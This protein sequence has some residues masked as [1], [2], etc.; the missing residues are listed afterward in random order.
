MDD[1]KLLHK[2]IEVVSDI[3]N[4][5]EKRFGEISVVREGK[6]TFLGMNIEINYNTI[7]FDMVK[8][9]EECI[10]ICGT[11][12]ITLVTSTATKKIFEVREYDEQ[13]IEKKG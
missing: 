12:I 8:H 4:E 13:L 3:I 9:L 2:N 7:Q 11:D 10:E 6:H 5:V 1:N